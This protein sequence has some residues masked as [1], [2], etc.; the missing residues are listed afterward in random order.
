[1]KVGVVGG[2]MEGVNLEQ[3]ERSF[4]LTLLTRV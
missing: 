1:V 2:T 4:G 3:V